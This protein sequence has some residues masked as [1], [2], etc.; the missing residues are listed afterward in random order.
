MDVGSHIEG[1]GDFR[2]CGL[3]MGMEVGMGTGMAFWRNLGN[4]WT[5]GWMDESDIGRELSG[6]REREVEMMVI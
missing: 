4:E 3:G 5:D 2:K 1:V 6:E